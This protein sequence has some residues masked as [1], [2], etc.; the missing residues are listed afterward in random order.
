M[1][2]PCIAIPTPVKFKEGLPAGVLVFG[3][4]GQ[5]KKLLK[6]AL[7]LEKAIKAKE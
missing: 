2:V 4:P 1:S 6:F 5:D 3:K 7:E